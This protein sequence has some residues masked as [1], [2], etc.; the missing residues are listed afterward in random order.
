MKKLLLTAG[1]AALSMSANAKLLLDLDAGAGAWFTGISDQSYLTDP[2][3]FNLTEDLG[4]ET[5]TNAYFWASIDQP[6]PII[7]DAKI[8]FQQ[9]SVAADIDASKVSGFDEIKFGGIA[10][11]D[12]VTVPNVSVDL[13]LTHYDLIAL[14]ELPLPLVE[15]GFGANLKII[16][17]SFSATAPA[18]TTN[19]ALDESGDIFLPLPLLYASAN[20]GVPGTGLE[21]GGEISWFQPGGNGVMDWQL[22]GRYMF[23]LPT[24]LLLQV[25]LEAGFKQFSM[26]FNED[27]ILG[28]DVS[29]YKAD[30][31]MSGAYVGLTAHF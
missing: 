30:I 10:L 3:R 5:G 20:V 17:G 16:D 12:F 25:G 24:D 31:T 26:A 27:E 29:E 7:P 15:I 22:G 8:R 2:E 21:V 18:T 1:I 4:F 28:Q 6:L 11:A 9:L 23:S 13:D 19:A 14:F